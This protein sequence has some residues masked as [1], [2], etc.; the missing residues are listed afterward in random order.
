MRRAPKRRKVLG[1]GIQLYVA[2]PGESWEKKQL[3]MYADKR[4]VYVHHDG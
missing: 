2:R 1:Q 4:G 3:G